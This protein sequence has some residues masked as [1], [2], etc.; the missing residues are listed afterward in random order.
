MMQLRENFIFKCRRL[1]GQ[2]LT[3]FVAQF[4]VDYVPFGEHGLTD[5]PNLVAVLV[6]PVG[7]VVVGPGLPP[8]T[9]GERVTSREVKPSAKSS[10]WS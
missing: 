10:Y 5:I 1:Q 3:P 4:P 7:R 8:E 2:W 6:V 9:L